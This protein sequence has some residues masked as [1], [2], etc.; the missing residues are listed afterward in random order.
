MQLFVNGQPREVP[1]GATVTGLLAELQLESAKVAVELNAEVVRKA[2]HAQ[3][4]LSPGDHVEI[5]TFV[6]GG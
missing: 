2:R 6:G 5:V 3:T 1:D 4:V